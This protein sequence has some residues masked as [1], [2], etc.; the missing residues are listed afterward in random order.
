MSV[1]NGS[2]V[3]EKS[4]LRPALVFLYPAMLPTSKTIENTPKSV[5]KPVAGIEIENNGS[6]WY[7]PSHPAPRE[8]VTGGHILQLLLISTMMDT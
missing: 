1:P 2:K 5:I 4:H 8:I 7:H 6:L 3:I